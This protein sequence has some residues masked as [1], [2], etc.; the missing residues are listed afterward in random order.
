MYQRKI[1]PNL[2]VHSHQVVKGA[3]QGHHQNKRENKRDQAQEYTFKQELP[4]QLLP[5]RSHHLAEAHFLGP[6]QR[7]G[8]TQVHES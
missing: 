7:P 2:Q 4:D 1:S 5:V 6:A 8:R 3:D